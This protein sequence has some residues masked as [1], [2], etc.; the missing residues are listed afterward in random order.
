MARQPGGLSWENR[1]REEGR[2]QGLCGE[3][4][5]CTF[6]QRGTIMNKDDLQRL[7]TQYSRNAKT[8][9]NAKEYN[10]Q[11]CR[12]EFI[13]PLLE[14]FGWDVHNKKGAPPQYKEVVVEKFSNQKERPDYT[15]TLNG[16]SKIFV[17]AK[18][19][20]VD[21]R[22][23]PAPARQARSYGWNA[24]HKISVLTNF[25]Y[26]LIF[27]A[28]NRPQEGDLPSVSL[29]QCYHYTQYLEAYPQ[30]YALLSRESVYSG[31]FDAFVNGNFQSSGRYAAQID[32]IFLEQ[33]NEWRL[34]IGRNLYGSS[35][36]YQDIDLLN[37]VVQEFINQMIFLRICEDR[38][39]PLYQSLKE[40]AADKEEL[41]SRLLRV[42]QEADKRYNSKLFAGDSILHDLDPD[43]VYRMIQALY[44]PQTP[45]LFHMIEPGILGK[46]YEAFLTE[47]L[48]LEQGQIVWTAKG[49][50]RYRSVV[51]T[52]TEI[53]KYMVKTALE[54]YCAGKTP[55][56]ILTLRVA[57]IACGSGVFLEEAYQY[58]ADYCVEWYLAHEPDYLLE[59]SNGKKKLPFEDKKTILINCIYGVDIDIHAVWVSR[60]S[61][62]IK[63]MEEETP[64]S[65]YDC[66][67]VLPDLHE[68]IR[69]G[70]ALVARDDLADEECSL[71][72][73]RSVIPF[74]W[75]DLWEGAAMEQEP[76][77]VGLEGNWKKPRGFGAGRTDFQTDGHGTAGFDVIVGN[78]PYVKTEDIHTLESETEFAV[79]KKKYQTAYKQFDKYFLFIEQAL[80]LLKEKG[81]L[82]Y[83]VPNKFFKIDAGQELRRLLADKILQ[84]DDFGDLQLFLD[85]TIY[86]SILL[87]AKE[88]SAQ[89]KYTNVTS[90]AGLWT[91]EEQDYI[92]VENASLGS[93]P[94]RLSTDIAFMKMIT[95]M[96][97]YA[98]PLG[99][100][101]NIFNGIQTSAE[102]PEP[103]YWF[104]QREVLAESEDL[105]LIRKFGREHTIEKSILKPYFKPTKADEKGMQTYSPLHTDKRI[106]FPYTQ[107]GDLIDIHSMQRDY[108]GTYAYLYS[109][110]D[111][112]V[113][114]CLNHGVGRDI[115]NATDENWYQYGRTQALTAFVHTPKLIVR[116]LSKR[117]MYAYDTQDMLIASGGT[118]GYCAIA[119]SKDCVYDLAYI[120]AW[121][122]HPYT[123]KL[124]RTMGSDFEGGFTAR[125]TYVLKKI[126][127]LELDLSKPDQKAAYDTVVSSAKKIYALNDAAKEKS[128]RTTQEVIEREKEKLA[129]RIEAQITGIYQLQFQVK[130]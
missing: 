76:F 28:T 98:R 121:L 100:I 40:S 59:Q 6:F 71:D 45:Y 35:Q 97:A 113:P 77:R 85:K 31:A 32:E 109:C 25:E 14:C 123:E 107:E 78:P 110:Y 91:G 4:G 50:Y 13:S 60:F 117:P 36:K 11:D 68:N 16:V 118:A 30:I 80:Q 86:S 70:N 47:C 48:I 10:E 103:I 124:L 83:I 5:L 96:E 46:I 120:Q 108:P 56:E 54:P 64:A 37:D 17:E 130:V 115:K 89:M 73:L 82:C 75:E 57:D 22:S 20:A 81:T 67:P 44:Y 23:E 41:C 94:W 27:D 7:I 52:P 43:I 112:L 18:K 38:N 119:A 8:Y 34:E 53:V 49:A 84:L 33:M 106:I 79:Y 92:M 42:F 105:V 3:Q 66:V 62:L 126:P 69:H 128:D 15:L 19:P 55:Q 122:N 24:K 87:C 102:R 2:V 58:L 95:R 1:K 65:V 93:A 90:L 63:L 129:R 21:I 26:L 9:R 61:L 39:L 51:S 72:L 74:S 88:G 114:K 29:Y 111:L 127:F 99:E 101:V 116:V 12:D 125:G 104:A